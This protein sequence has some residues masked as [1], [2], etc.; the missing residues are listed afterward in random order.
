MWLPLNRN[1]YGRLFP[2][3]HGKRSERGLRSGRRL[4]FICSGAL[5]FLPAL[6]I[7]QAMSLTGRSSVQTIKT[8]IYGT[9]KRT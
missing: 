4:N 7:L 9:E 6:C 1:L 2:Y 8:N 5:E 3:G